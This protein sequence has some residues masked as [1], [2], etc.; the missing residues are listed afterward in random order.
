[1]FQR[2]LTLYSFNLAH[3]KLL[4]ADLPEETLGDRP[5]SGLKPARWVLGHL[6]ISTDLALR[7]VGQPEHCPPA[8]H[9]AFGPGSALEHPDVA[10]TKAELV[11]AIEAGHGYVSAA[12][13]PIQR[14]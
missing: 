3:L 12:R 10:P 1:M 13:R 11:A 4:A 7:C 8:W 14:R 6:A 2:E 5:A 9:E